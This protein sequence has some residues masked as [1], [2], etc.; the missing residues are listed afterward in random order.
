M[1]QRVIVA[2]VPRSYREVLTWAFEEFR[3]G[4]EVVSVDPPLNDHDIDQFA[5]QLVICSCLSRIVRRAPA[6]I[7]LYPAGTSE[8]IVSLTGS[9]T[10]LPSIDFHQLLDFVDQALGLAQLS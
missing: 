5:P 8:A 6:W 2:N 4:V 1:S 9:H 7:V 10:I 3:P